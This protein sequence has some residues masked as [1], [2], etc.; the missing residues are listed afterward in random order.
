MTIYYKLLGSIAFLSYFDF[1]SNKKISN[2]LYW[3]LVIVIV[4]FSG[5]IVLA[6]EIGGL[7][8]ALSYRGR[9]LISKDNLNEWENRINKIQKDP[10]PFIDA[11]MVAKQKALMFEDYKQI[12]K[13]ELI[14][15]NHVL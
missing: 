3:S 10:I 15:N 7:P 2:I 1:S 14:L 8:E 4:L 9:L 13:L 5:K 6:S 12:E 11:S